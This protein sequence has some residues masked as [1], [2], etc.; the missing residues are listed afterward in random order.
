MPSDTA[1][2]VADKCEIEGC[3]REA[4]VILNDQCVCREHFREAL[5]G[6]RANMEALSALTGDTD[7]Q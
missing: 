3:E 5:S 2:R 4:L 6:H 1:E 7:G